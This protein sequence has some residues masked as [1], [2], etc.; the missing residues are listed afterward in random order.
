MLT[1]LASLLYNTYENHISEFP[2]ITY[3]KYVPELP[4]IIY[5]KHTQEAPN[6][7]RG[8]RAPKLWNTNYEKR[9]PKFTFTM[10]KKH[11]TQVMRN[12]CQIPWIQRLPLH[13]K[14]LISKL[15][16]TIRVATRQYVFPNT[17]I[18]ID[19]FE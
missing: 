11:A 2:T 3:G 10:R 7:I 9:A 17:S 19:G 4:D 13:Q 5:Q 15:E 1:Q 8:K 12:E 14:S 18:T 6:T 16:C